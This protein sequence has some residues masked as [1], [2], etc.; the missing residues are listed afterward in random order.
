M[1]RAAA[2]LPAATAW[3][4]AR[5]RGIRSM[6]RCELTPAEGK[7]RI[8][9]TQVVAVLLAATQLLAGCATS[10]IDRDSAAPHKTAPQV[11]LN[12][13]KGPDEPGAEEQSPGA[14]FLRERPDDGTSISP[15][16]P[17]ISSCLRPSRNWIVVWTCRFRSPRSTC[18]NIPRRRST[19]TLTCGSAR[20]TLVWD[21]RSRTVSSGRPTQARALG[22]IE[23]PGVR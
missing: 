10:G 15:S 17:V 13:A 22:V 7:V 9:G 12:R 2:S 11:L 4:V 6:P 18:F 3:R 20:S 21:A 16:V 23:P 1:S 19:E 14:I 8:P 5:V